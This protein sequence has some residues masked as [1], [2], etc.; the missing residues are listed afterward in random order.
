M[1][2]Y[3]TTKTSKHAMPVHCQTALPPLNSLRILPA[4]GGES[5]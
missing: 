5:Q 1:N 3:L 2:D 4:P